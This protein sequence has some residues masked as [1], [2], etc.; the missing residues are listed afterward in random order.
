MPD[1]LLRACPGRCGRFVQR[2]RCQDCQRA[3]Y[4]AEDLRRGSAAARGYGPKWTATSKALRRGK[5][6]WCGDTIR[7]YP[8]G[9]SRCP[10][11]T[12]LRVPSHVVDHIVPVTGP[13][14]PNFWKR[15]NWQGL[16]ES[17]HNV[18]RQRESRG[19]VHQDA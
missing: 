5:L 19:L 8:T 2:G 10:Q 13:H 14:D 18:K 9:D 4:Q 7:G 3:K 6:R 15:E 1:A 17:C 12:L 16:C 11:E